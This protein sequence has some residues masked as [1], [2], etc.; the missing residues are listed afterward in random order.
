MCEHLAQQI[1]FKP[2][3]ASKS[4]LCE[5]S[6]TYTEPVSSQSVHPFCADS[7]QQVMRYWVQLL[8]ATKQGA[9]C[10][11]ETMGPSLV[12]VS[13][14]QRPVGEMNGKSGNLNNCFS[15]LYPEG[16]TIPTN[17][18]MCIF[19]ADQASL[20]ASFSHPDQGSQ[21]VQASAY[22]CTSA[23][24]KRPETSLAMQCCLQGS[25]TRCQCILSG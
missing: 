5:A 9:G 21:A 23:F 3:D 1:M 25:F 2:Q 18:L 13:G 24:W 10:R 11:V 4:A 14:R 22:A 7:L 19:D 16:C 20:A 6:V 8:Q 17:E 15:Q 12:Y